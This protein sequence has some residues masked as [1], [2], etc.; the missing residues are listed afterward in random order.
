MNWWILYYFI[1]TKLEKR[2]E[3]KEEIA[4]FRFRFQEIEMFSGFIRRLNLWFFYCFLINKACHSRIFIY[5]CN[6]EERLIH[7][8]LCRSVICFV[9][10]SWQFGSG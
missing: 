1:A 5:I 4:I 7:H 3:N 8:I 9:G 10:L 2:Y 6:Y